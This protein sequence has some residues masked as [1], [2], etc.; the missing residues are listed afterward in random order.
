MRAISVAGI[1]AHEILTG[2]KKEDYRIWEPNDRKGRIL[3]CSAAKKQKGF[4]CGYALCT[5]E[6]GK[7]TKYPPGPYDDGPM[8]G[9]QLKKVRF[10]EP[11]PVKSR[12]R[13]TFFEVDDDLVA[14]FKGIDLQEWFETYYDPIRAWKG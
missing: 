8:Y 7:V 1:D 4:V 2:A 10:I 5:A 11:F 12:N 3:I 13:L 6:I 9:W 14:E